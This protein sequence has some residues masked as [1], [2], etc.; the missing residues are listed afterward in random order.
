MIDF[1]KYEGE[2]FAILAQMYSIE[3]NDAIKQYA[4]FKA[5]GC[6]R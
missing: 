6:A 2:S 3:R 1:T 5:Q 4:R